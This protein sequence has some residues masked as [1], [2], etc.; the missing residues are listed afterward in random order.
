MDPVTHGITGALLGKAY[1]SKRDGRVAVFA[2]TLGGLFPDVDVVTQVFS[3]DP[4][5]IIK[6]HR[7][8]TH[9]FVALP[10]LAMLLAYLTRGALTL[11]KRRIARFRE[12]EA[13]SWLV[14]T[15]IYGV[16]IASH[17]V[18]DAMTSFGTRVW[19]PFSQQRLAWDMLF[20]VDFSFTSVVLLPQVI[21]WIY[22]N[23]EKSVERAVWMWV[24]FTLGAFAVW[25]LASGTGFPF[26]LWIAGIVSAVMAALFFG[27]VLRGWGFRVSRPVWC[28]GGTCVMLA[29]LL[30]CAMAH[31]AALGRVKEFAAEN[32]IV[33]DRIGAIPLPPSMV[34]WGG[35]IRSVAGVYQ[36]RF[37]LRDSAPPVFL[38]AAD[39]P[40]DEFTA[41]A[42][43]LPEV[44][45]YWQFARF[46]LIHSSFKDGHHVVD[47]GENR[48]FRGHR[49]RPQPFTY[50]V[51]FDDAGN[52][53][54]QG[55]E[56]DGM[57]NRQMKQVQPRRSGE[58]P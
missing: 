34:A 53:I 39:S 9:S 32:D 58:T 30:A 3:R 18:L 36:S 25:I 49:D 16:T 12:I 17:I 46:P 43:R 1:F 33:I 5:S 10:F 38:F 45:I 29:Y 55:W 8:I 56:S 41:R 26:H 54:E 2:A 23:R 35:L 19:S 4:L 40:P 52:V 27:P 13:P 47:F 57:S 14:L 20:I 37:D 15:L 42:M 31:H 28:Q 24:L 50:R 7:D 11:L 48:F 21:A 44:R 51:V 6:Y 22:R